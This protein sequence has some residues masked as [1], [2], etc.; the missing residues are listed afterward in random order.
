MIRK[1]RLKH[2]ALIPAR[3]GS[4][5]IK[6]KNLKKICGKSLVKI[7][8]DQCVE[9]G[10]F[11]LMI[12]STDKKE[13]AHEISPRI[14][15]ESLN[16]NSYS[17]F[18]KNGILH[19]RDSFQSETYSLISNLT[20]KISKDFYIENLWIIQPT[21]PFRLDQDFKSLKKLAENEVH[22]TSLISVKLTDTFHPYKMYYEREY[23]VPVLLN[24]F[25]DSQP[26]QL[27]PKIVIKD[28]AFYILKGKNLE[29]NIFLGDK[30][31][32]YVRS[33]DFNVNIDTP[34]DL[35]IARYLYREFRDKQ[36]L[37]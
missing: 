16:E 18:G 12:L 15:F 17:K 27:L 34:E 31:K 19:K 37:N 3:G 32:S 30:V 1:Y 26:R 23:L 2:V 33:S 5:G 4:T 21:S 8:W 13:I 24:N 22:W 28:G 6:N 20:F 36:T 7:A 10:F 9:T 29:N 35:K 25:D 14:D 11:D